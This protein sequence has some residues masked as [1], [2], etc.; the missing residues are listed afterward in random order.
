MATLITQHNSD[1]LV[2]RCDEKCYGAKC[3]D[4][5][6]ICGGRNHG[7][8][9]GQALENTRELAETWAAREGVRLDFTPDALCEPLF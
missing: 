5:S 9:L 8:G 3:E 2:G 4:C 6:C 7:T 1:G